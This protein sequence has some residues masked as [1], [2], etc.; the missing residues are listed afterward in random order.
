MYYIHVLVQYIINTFAYCYMI[1]TCSTYD[2]HRVILLEVYENASIQKKLNEIQDDRIYLVNNKSGI[3]L[4]STPYG[5][6]TFPMNNCV[7]GTASR[8][9][10]E[11]IIV[12]K[13]S[14]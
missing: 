5:F 4:P 12:N 3:W 10:F 6:V 7:R 11:K 14:T 1:H 8:N 9:I 13:T 2:L